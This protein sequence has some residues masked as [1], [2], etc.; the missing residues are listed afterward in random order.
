MMRFL[1]IVLFMV[2]L[3]Q[4]VLAQA[5]KTPR[6]VNTKLM[7]SDT[8][9][10]TGPASV[11]TPIYWWQAHNEMSLEISMDD[12]SSAGFASDS[13]SVSVTLMQVFDRGLTKTVRLYTSSAYTGGLLYDT[14]ALADLDTL[15]T[16]LRVVA[17]IMRYARDTVGYYGT[18]ALD[19]LTTSDASAYKLVQPNYSPGVLLKITGLGANKVGSA[20]KIIVRWYQR[21]G[22]PVFNN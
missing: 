15:G 19:T 22:I 9:Y 5:Y 21:L 8:L 6:V 4:V 17:P 18:N 16:W 2:V 1:F 13:V 10:V 7:R 3:A 12:T 14:L 20:N 11:Y